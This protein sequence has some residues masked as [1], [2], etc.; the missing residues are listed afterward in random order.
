M[1]YVFYKNFDVLHLRLKLL[2]RN[3]VKKLPIHKIKKDYIFPVIEIRERR[4][5]VKQGKHLSLNVFFT[6]YKKQIAQMNVDHVVEP[7]AFCVKAAR[8]H[9]CVQCINI[10][11]ILLLIT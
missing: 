6:M 8:L 1:V 11:R 5:C 10:T 2:Y 9:F 4:G 3:L 7:P